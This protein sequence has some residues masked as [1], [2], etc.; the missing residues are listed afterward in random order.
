MWNNNYGINCVILILAEIQMKNINLGGYFNINIGG[1]F[2]I[3]I[4]ILKNNIDVDIF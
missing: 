2:N 1:Y 3:N 4:E